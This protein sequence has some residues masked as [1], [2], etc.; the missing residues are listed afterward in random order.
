MVLRCCRLQVPSSRLA[1]TGKLAERDSRSGPHIGQA[2]FSTCSAFA[3]K[4]YYML[5]LRRIPRDPA[6]DNIVDDRLQA[7]ASVVAPCA[8]PVYSRV[9]DLGRGS[10]SS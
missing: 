1:P 3:A 7:W 6:V 10:E 2:D 8:E 9:A 5:W 4:S